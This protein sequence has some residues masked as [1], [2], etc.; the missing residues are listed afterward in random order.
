M[1]AE[2]EDV[3]NLMECLIKFRKLHMNQDQ[4]HGLKSNDNYLMFYIKRF[5]TQDP[6]GVKVS[7]LSNILNV[8]SPTITQQINALELNGYVERSIDKEDRRVI[9]IKLT[10]KGEAKIIENKGILFA[11]TTE[12]A[13]YLGKEDCKKLTE[14]VTKVFNFISS[15]TNQSIN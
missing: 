8:T 5:L 12:L 6:S 3:Q 7:E 14:L 2:S 1:Q 9:R 11:Y 10:E 15:K 4:M 13:D